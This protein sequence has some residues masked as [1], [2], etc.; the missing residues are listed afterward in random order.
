MH[1]AISGGLYWMQTVKFTLVNF[2]QSIL[3]PSPCSVKWRY[4]VTA[5]MP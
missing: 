5:H 1:K 2:L 4:S 3:L